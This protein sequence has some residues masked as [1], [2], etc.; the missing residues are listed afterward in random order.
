[1]H[2]KAKLSTE[3]TPYMALITTCFAALGIALETARYL[4]RFPQICMNADRKSAYYATYD[5][6]DYNDAFRYEWENGWPVIAQESI[7]GESLAHDHGHGPLGLSVISHSYHH[8]YF[9]C[10]AIYGR[11]R[12]AWDV[13][14]GHCQAVEK[15]VVSD[16]KD[17]L[18]KV[19][20]LVLLDV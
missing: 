20:L 2:D 5:A 13:Q 6:K 11:R 7:A 18:K 4:E 12:K 3:V 16:Q 15:Q 19:E 17:M 9:R 1:M 14:F 8:L 10:Y